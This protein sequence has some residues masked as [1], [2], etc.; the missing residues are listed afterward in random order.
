[1]KDLDLDLW[2]DCGIRTADELASVI[3][4][5]VRVVIAGLETVRG[6]SALREIIDAAGP[7]R[8]AFSLDLRDGKPLVETRPDWGTDDPIRLAEAAVEFGVKRLILL[9]LAH[10]GRG[11]GTGTLPLLRS[12]RGSHPHV[13]IVAGG[14]ISGPDDLRNLRDAGAAAALVGSALHDGRLGAESIA[15]AW[16]DSP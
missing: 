11:T 2:V 4:S 14:G 3:N 13:E 1:M 16:P 10:V 8:L 9:D 15:R 7:D 6:L 12:L 5:G